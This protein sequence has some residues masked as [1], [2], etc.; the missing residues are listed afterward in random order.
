MENVDSTQIKGK[1]LYN[2]QLEELIDLALVDGKITAKEKQVLFK[3]AQS[4]GVDLDEFE[5]VLEAKLVKL[6]QAKESKK[7]KETA[8]SDSSKLGRAK[9]CPNCGATIGSF[10]MKCPECGFEFSGI[11]PNSYVATFSKEL[12]AELKAFNEK[13]K[14]EKKDKS[15]KHSFFSELDA[16]TASKVFYDFVSNYPLPLTKEDC[17][18]MLN[19]IL[20][21][22]GGVDDEDDYLYK[23]WEA[24]YNAI[25]SKME[26]D[27]S[28]DLSIRKL[29][30]RY[31]EK[32]LSI[33]KKRRKHIAIKWFIMCGFFGVVVI[34]GGI[35]AGISKAKEE[36]NDRILELIKEGNLFDAKVEIKKGG[37]PLPLYEYYM[38]NE[39]WDDAE[40]FIPELTE[41]TYFDYC[42][43]AVKTMVSK[44]K[45]SEAKSF[46]NRKIVF[47]EDFDDK[48]KSGHKKWNTATVSKKLNKLIHDSN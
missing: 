30:T 22:L 45:I 10:K 11:G 32:G 23:L 17:I 5:M 44:G 18:E 37:D 12:K 33:K 31:R 3:K 47:Y 1:K 16:P 9:K 26:E 20:S 8:P 28:S 2:P 25:L 43:K 15:V 27:S 46:I 24:K 39:M 42:K 13:K 41:E 4:L 35:W 21:K 6:E 34:G 19:F 38:E 7:A 36:S 40:E 48:S 14:E 29:I